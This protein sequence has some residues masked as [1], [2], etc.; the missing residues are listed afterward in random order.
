MSKLRAKHI[1]VEHQFEADDLVKKLSEGK[2]F[3]ELAAD[4]SQCPSGKD[5]GDLGEF[6]KGMMVKPF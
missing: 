4:F 5:G 3:E 1:L 2:T 6:S